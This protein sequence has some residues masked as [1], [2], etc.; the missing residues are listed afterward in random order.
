MVTSLEGEHEELVQQI[1][2]QIKNEGEKNITKIDLRRDYDVQGSDKTHRVDIYWKFQIRGNTYSV[3]VKVKDSRST[4]D[5]E[6]LFQLKNLLEDLHE[7]TWGVVVTCTGYQKDVLEYAERNHILLYELQASSET[8][9]IGRIERVNL[10]LH[11]Y[12]PQFTNIKFEQDVEWNAQEL[13]RLKIP[14]SEAL[15]IKV[16]GSDDLKFYDEKGNDFTKALKFFNSLVPK[17]FNELPPTKIV[18]TF[19]KPTFVETTDPRVKM[20]IKSVEVTI[21]KMHIEFQLGGE[22]FV[23]FVIRNIV[24]GTSTALSGGS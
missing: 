6:Q 3:I 15:K 18:H 21:S 1:Y 11:V 17:G 5:I 19:D 10:D 2:D 23:E 16:E 20:K 24:A 13:A 14:L 7:Q 8:D 22:N 12:Q 9:R 4:V